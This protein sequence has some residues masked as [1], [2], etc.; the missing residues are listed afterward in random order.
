MAKIA[1]PAKYPKFID[2]DTT[3]PA[4]SPRVVAAILMMGEIA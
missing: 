2:I 1:V 4:V 3:S